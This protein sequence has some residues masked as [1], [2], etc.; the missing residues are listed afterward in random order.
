VGIAKK[1]KPADARPAK[2]GEVI[3][4]VILGEGEETRSANGTVS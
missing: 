4:T 1:T 2:P 3:V